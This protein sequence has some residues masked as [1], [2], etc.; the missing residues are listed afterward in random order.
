MLL[1]AYQS[2]VKKIAKREANQKFDWPLFFVN[3]T[4]YQL[5]PSTTASLKI[6]LTRPCKTLP[7]PTSVK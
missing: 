2:R 5:T 7:G 1:L 6:L 4:L 3:P